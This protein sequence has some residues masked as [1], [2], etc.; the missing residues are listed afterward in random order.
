MFRAPHGKNLENLG[1]SAA[2]GLLQATGVVFI[3]NFLLIII[4]KENNESIF[5]INILASS[6]NTP[7]PEYFRLR[8]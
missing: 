7:E 4:S 2:Y 6:P 3:G 1:N 8:G 5:M